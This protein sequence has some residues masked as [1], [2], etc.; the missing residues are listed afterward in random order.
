MKI[1]KKEPPQEETGTIREQHEGVVK[2]IEERT[3]IRNDLLGKV[4]K[5]LFWHEHNSSGKLPEKEALEVA[6]QLHETAKRTSDGL[7]VAQ[8]DIAGMA[9]NMTFVT[10]QLEAI[11]R[12]L[13]SKEVIT[14]DDLKEAFGKG[15]E[16]PATILQE[17]LESDSQ[18][19]GED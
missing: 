4:N 17:S 5:T 9:V 10:M 15:E 16:E 3:K 13:L 7:H 2:K 19:E 18:S 12:I 14:V 8:L 6:K 1:K 11:A